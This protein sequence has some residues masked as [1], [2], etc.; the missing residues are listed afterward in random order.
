MPRM[1]LLIVV[2]ALLAG[3]EQFNDAM[4]RRWHEDRALGGKVNDQISDGYRRRM[5]LPP[6]PAATQKPAPEGLDQT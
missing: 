4:V 5:Q 3:C 6:P 2:A 1:I